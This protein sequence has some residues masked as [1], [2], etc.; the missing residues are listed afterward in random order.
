MDKELVDQVVETAAGVVAGGAI[1]AN[2]HGNV[3][4]RVPGADEMYYTVRPVA[5]RAGGRRASPA[6]A[7]TGRCWRAS[8]RRSRAP[9]WRC[10]R[11]CTR[12]A[13]T[14]A[15]S[16]TPTR[17]TPR[18]SPSPTGPSTA[19]SRPSPCSASPTAS[20]S[21]AYGPRGSE[22]AVAN[23][24]AAVPPGRAGRAARQPRRARLPP[25]A[26]AGRPRRRGRRGG[27]PGGDQ[28]RLRSAARSRSR[29]TCG[30]PPSSGRWRSTPRARGPPDGSDGLG[31]RLVGIDARGRGALQ[32]VDGVG[33][34]VLDGEAAGRVVGAESA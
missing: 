1:S 10:T 20:P 19:G 24:R 12:T 15:A 8:C 30:R 18:P 2:G 9:S 26:G 32:E 33:D 14:W 23:I 27:G 4:V 3:S 25:H 28:R 29:R 17:R 5:T 16:S 22:Q 34:D 7:W 13:P 11:P 31:V 6:S 21:P